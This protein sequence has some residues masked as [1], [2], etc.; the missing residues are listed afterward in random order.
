[1]LMPVDAG[2]QARSFSRILILSTRPFPY[3]LLPS[4]VMDDSIISP[5]NGG[6]SQT[7]NKKHASSQL[8]ANSLDNYRIEWASRQAATH[9]TS[10]VFKVEDGQVAVN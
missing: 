7:V 9:L 5:F 1:M 8:G 6:W 4:L 10:L 3:T 2:E